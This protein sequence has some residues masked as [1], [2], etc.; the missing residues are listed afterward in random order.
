VYYSEYSPSQVER[1]AQQLAE[2]RQGR[3]VWCIF[4]NTAAGTATGNALALQGRL[5]RFQRQQM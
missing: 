2:L 4:D 1:L 5:R 3:T